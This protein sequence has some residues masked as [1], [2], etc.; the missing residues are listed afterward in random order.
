MQNLAEI[1]SIKENI[2]VEVLD[3][4]LLEKKSDT[5]RECVI[6]TPVQGTMT[7]TYDIKFSGSLLGKKVPVVA[8]EFVNSGIVIRKIGVDKASPDIAQRYPKLLKAK[9]CGFATAVGLIGLPLESE[10]ILQAVFKDK[11]KVPIARVKF[12]RLCDLAS[13]YQPQ[14]QPLIL[15]C[16]GRSGTTWLMGLLREHPN[17]LVAGGYPYEVLAAQ[18]WIHLLKVI[19]EPANTLESTPQLHPFAKNFNFIGHHPFY[20]TYG[21]S[22]LSS[23]FGKIYPKQLASFCQQS[24]D[25]FYQQTANIGEKKLLTT[26]KIN[27]PLQSEII[28]F[29]EKYHANFPHILQIL[30]ELYPQA[31]EIFLVRDFRDVICSK[32]AREIKMKKLRRV[33]Q[34][35]PEKEWICEF[36]QSAIQP[37]L[38]RWRQRS[39]DVHLVRYE[40]LI[41]SPNETL[42]NL[43]KYLGLDNSSTIVNTILQTA[44]ADTSRLKQHLTSSSPQASIGRW[45]NELTPTL[46]NLCN[47]VFA[48][49]LQEFGYL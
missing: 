26:E 33:N 13:S 9:K 16:L 25:G 31:S 29:A 8:I 23:W 49:A 38:Q 20:N 1:S 6:N 45:Q 43:L 32:K 19:S 37:L 14:L 42:S 44:S 7:D 41:M 4:Q 21:D 3:V 12:R 39:G 48:K 24:I 28:Y 35:K 30:L 17:I 22:N 11:S 18:Y 27:N 2:I 36:E 15:T 5:L 34:L 46:Q 40:D 47:Q 10:L